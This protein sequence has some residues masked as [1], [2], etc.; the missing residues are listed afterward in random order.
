M[1]DGPFRLLLISFGRGGVGRVGWLGLGRG[2][3]A[4]GSG[5]GCISGKGGGV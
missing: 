3:W 1:A 5:L 2:W 4:C